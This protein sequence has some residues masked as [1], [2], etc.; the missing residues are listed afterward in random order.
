MACALHG[1]SDAA[2]VLLARTGDAAGQDLSLLVQETLEE[3]GIF[4]VDVLD[5]A[6]AETAI[7]LALGVDGRSGEIADFRLCL[8]HCLV[9]LSLNF[10]AAAFCILGSI[11]L[12]LHGDE[13]KHA[14]VAAVSNFQFLNHSG[15]GIELEECVETSGLLLNGIRHLLEAPIL[16]IDD[17]C[18]L[19]GENTFELFDRL[20]H[21]R[22]RQNGSKDEDGLV[23]IRHFLL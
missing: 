17:L 21:L 9:L 13:A 19:G 10:V 7:L 14:L 20:L 22:F 6:L 16:F 4:V 23:L 2:L 1:L 8:C 15:L 12:I 11:L 3:F 18:A 5:T